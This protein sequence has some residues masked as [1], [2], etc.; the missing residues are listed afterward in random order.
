MILRDPWML[1]LLALVFALILF[2]KGRKREAGIRFSSGILL[3]SLRPTLKLRMTRNIILLRALA[4]T[5]IIISLARPQSYI[6]ES[7]IQTEGIDIVL[8]LDV[9]TSMLAEDFVLKGKRENRLKVV[10]DVVRDFIKARGSDKIGMVAF[11][12]RA[13]TV[14]PL[15]LDYGWLLQNLERVEIGMME[16]GTAVGSGI[17]SGLN[18]LKDAEAKSKV[19]ILLTDGINNAGRIS[20]LTAAEA[21][22]VLKT[23]IYTIGA[24]TKGLAPYPMKDPFGRTVYQSVK[25]DIDEDILKRIAE[26]TDAKY[27][28][29][30][31]TE[32]LRDIYRE[33]DRLEKTVIEE[34]GYVE[35]KEL[36]PLFLIPGIIILL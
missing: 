14:C 22:R 15:T 16:D 27:F 23:K 18:R 20:P 36:F 9:S 11:A 12:G 1:L 24:G 4:L 17:S 6:E 26:K 3:N 8:A 33:I 25:I 10:K 30:T 32:S 34:K 2:V 28:R 19:M 13:Y 5:L 7:V 35:Y 21:A 29:A 31:D